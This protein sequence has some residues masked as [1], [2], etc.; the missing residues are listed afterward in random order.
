MKRP[1]QNETQSI[2]SMGK[3]NIMDLIPNFMSLLG[4]G[5][6]H[7]PWRTLAADEIHIKVF[8]L[9]Q[10]SIS[11]YIPIKHWFVLSMLFEYKLKG[12]VC[13]SLTSLCHSNGHIE[14]MPAREINPFTALTR[15]RSQFLRTQCSRTCKIAP[16]APPPWSSKTNF[17]INIFHAFQDLTCLRLN[18]HCESRFSEWFSKWPPSKMKFC[19]TN[20]I[21]SK[22]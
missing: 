14:T 13:W 22:N 10:H 20:V 18:F 19:D 5:H 4:N 17:F 2:G 7:H 15:I 21:S 6:V 8:H 3:L 11:E 12:L 16:P 9:P 1:H